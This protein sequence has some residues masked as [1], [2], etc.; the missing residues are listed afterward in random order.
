MFY[1]VNFDTAVLDKI[2]FFKNRNFYLNKYEYLESDDRGNLLLDKQKYLG[3]RS[4][5]L[6]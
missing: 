6:A 2:G 1:S 5:K 3:K 4:G